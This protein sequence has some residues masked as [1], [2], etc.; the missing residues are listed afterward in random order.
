VNIRCVLFGERGE[1]LGAGGWAA[2]L[3]LS[4][5][6][7]HSATDRRSF[8]SVLSKRKKVFYASGAALNSIFEIPFLWNLSSAIHIEYMQVK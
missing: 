4:G 2:R 1:T 6:Q 5:L 3:N 7:A 8:G